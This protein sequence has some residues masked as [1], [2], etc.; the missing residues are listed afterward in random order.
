MRDPMLR[1][2]FPGPGACRRS[3]SRLTRS[4]SSATSGFRSYEKKMEYSSVFVVRFAPRVRAH[5]TLGCGFAAAR[6]RAARSNVVPT[7]TAGPGGFAKRS[8]TLAV[9]SSNDKT[10]FPGTELP[11]TPARK[12]EPGLRRSRTPLAALHLLERAFSPSSSPRLATGARSSPVSRA[13]LPGSCDSAFQEVTGNCW[14][15]LRSVSRTE[16]CDPFGE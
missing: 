5:R 1:R 10:R 4:T 14:D 16:L 2:R 3:T 13:E 15:E 9:R 12:L 11:S 8:I 6:V 7:R